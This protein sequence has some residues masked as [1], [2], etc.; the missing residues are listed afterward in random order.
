MRNFSKL[1]AEQLSEINK[2]TAAF[3]VISLRRNW[4]SKFR[5]PKPLRDTRYL[6][7]Y[8][9]TGPSKKLFTMQC[10]TK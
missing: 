7:F 9:E 10:K 8:I 3:D 5:V 1:Y 6:A 2:A 4:F